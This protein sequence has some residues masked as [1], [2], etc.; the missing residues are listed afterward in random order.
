MSLPTTPPRVMRGSNGSV[1]GAS[2]YPPIPAAADNV[3]YLKGDGT[4]SALSNASA[5]TNAEASAGTS[6]TT[7]V[8]PANAGL[9][10]AGARNALAPA[11]ALSGNGTATFGTATLASSLGTTAHT[12]ALRLSVPA[13][14][15]SGFILT[16]AGNGN[17]PFNDLYCYL[18]AGSLVANYRFASLDHVAVLSSGF[19]TAYGGTTV[20]LQ[21]VFDGTNALAYINSVLVSTNALAVNLTGATALALGSSTWVGT[22]RLLGI[23][24]RALSAT[25]VLALYRESDPA[26]ADYNVASNTAIA[27][28]V[29]VGNVSGGASASA[30]T[31]TAASGISYATSN[32]NASLPIL[33]KGQRIRVTGTLTMN[34]GSTNYPMVYSDSLAGTTNQLTAGGAFS[35][36]ITLGSGLTTSGLVFVATGAANYSVSG[37]AVTR[38]GLLLAPDSAQSGGGLTWYDTSGNAANITLPATGVTWNVPTSGRGI[39]A[40]GT[41]AAPS[42]S[43]AADTDTGRYRISSDLIGESVGGIAALSIGRISATEGYIG[44]PGG[45]G[46]GY[47]SFTTTGAI[48]LTAAGTN[49]NITLTPSGTG[50]T[51]LTRTGAG[52]V[53]LTLTQPA[54]T[55]WQLYNP[56]FT[57]DFRLKNGTDL[58][59]FQSNG[60]FLIGTTTDSGALLQ[61]GTNATT[62]SAGGLVFGTD[63]FM[64]RGGSAAGMLTMQGIGGAGFIFQSTGSPSYTGGI[65]V[66]AQQ[67]ALIISQSGYDV[68]RTNGF[69]VPSELQLLTTG[70]VALTLDS[71]Q[72]AIFAG[73]IFAK[74]SAGTAVFAVDTTS[75]SDLAIANNAVAYPFSNANNFAGLIVVTDTS[76]T[77]NSAVF[78][79]SASN[80]ILVSQ[81]GSSF[82]N[83][84]GT[85][86]KTNFYISG[87]VVVIEN[88]SGVSTNYSVQAHRTRTTS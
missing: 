60:R 20:D 81:T 71:S 75:G 54:V 14:Q 9:A 40:D 58:F 25:E 78:L 35:V 55:T 27:N 48:A 59:S 83:T 43:F 85:A 11:Q 72:N 6:T 46:V 5:A 31:V 4:W 57:T 16:L 84:S 36:E 82:S 61:I 24:N 10:V 52:D 37:L 53:S 18:S 2:G 70:T 23:Y 29:F 42:I 39:F 63:T 79:T 45:S 26:S 3:K 13:A 50:V 1:A 56:A 88:K 44:G 19:V 32:L 87:G 76:N 86:A 73:T 12:I 22:I 66:S 15:Q 38:L 8:T 62:T 74:K 80:M 28:A 34:S 68:I 51:L 17:A 64:F 30:F 67:K 49:R 33:S 77:G 65:L 47:L 69:A 41:A 7:F 21:L